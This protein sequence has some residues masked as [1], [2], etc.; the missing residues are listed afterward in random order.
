MTVK[1]FF[2][3]FFNFPKKNT[4]NFTVAVENHLADMWQEC[5]ERL[6]GK[7]IV[8]KNKA[9][10]TESGRVWKIQY[11]QGDNKSELTIHFYN[12][13]LKTK[14]SKFLVQ[15]GNHATKYLFVFNEMPKIYKMVCEI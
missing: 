12:K 2:F 10:G 3:D 8:N 7:L 9:T 15:G 11:S 13:P 1:K 4:D 5:F 14:K 6:F